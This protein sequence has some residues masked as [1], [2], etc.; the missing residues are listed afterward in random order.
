MTLSFEGN[1]LI[2]EHEILS[3]KTKLFEAAQCV[4]FVILASTGLMQLTSVTDRQTD[5]QTD[6]H[7]DDG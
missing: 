1:L 5:E 6:G 7:L 2:P 4:D 3:H